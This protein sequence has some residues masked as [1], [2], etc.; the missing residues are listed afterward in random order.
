MYYYYHFNLMLQRNTARLYQLSNSSGETVLNEIFLH[1]I[2]QING[3]RDR[4]FRTWKA[5]SILEPHSVSAHT[6]YSLVSEVNS[7]TLKL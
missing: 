7:S 3:L 1:T 4:H 5:T 2:I 6:F